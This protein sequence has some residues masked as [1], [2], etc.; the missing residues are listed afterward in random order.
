MSFVRRLIYL[1][2]LLRF[3]QEFFQTFF[4][5]FFVS[6]FHSSPYSPR[7]PL[8]F[9]LF[10]LLAYASVR[11]LCYNT[12]F[13]PFCQHLFSIFFPLYK[14]YSFHRHLSIFHPFL[15]SVNILFVI[16]F[17]YF[18]L[19]PLYLCSSHFISRAERH[20]HITNCIIFYYITICISLQFL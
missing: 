13:P 19:E 10:S 16:F 20:L 1:T 3:C 18:Y 2:T 17:A 14:L 8:V 5:V 12:T 6:R 9:K 15:P 7:K 11:Q 4:Q